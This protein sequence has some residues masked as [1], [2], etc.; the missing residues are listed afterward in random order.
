VVNTDTPSI[1]VLI[2]VH[3]RR[4]I[5]IQCLNHLKKTQEWPKFNVLVIDDGS[6]DGTREA[7]ETKFPSVTIL[8]GDGSL[9][10]GGS[11]KKGMKY[12]KDKGADVFIWLND[13]VHPETEGVTKLADK[14][15]ELGDTVLTTRVE[16]NS[17]FRNMNYLSD[18][19]IGDIQLLSSSYSTCQIKTCLGMR[20]APY[21]STSQIQSCDATA[22]KFTAFPAKIVDDIGYPDDK[23]FPHNYCDHDYTL[24][25]K[26]QGFKIGVY[27]KISAQDT[28]HELKSSRLS[29]EISLKELIK[30]NFYPGVRES[31]NIETRYR[32]YMQF[33]GPP[34]SIP[35]LVF[36]VYFIISIIFIGVKLALVI[37][38]REQKLVG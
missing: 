18:F 13:D 35:Y 27:T 5:T 14:T 21:D 32:R 10:W 9:W 12:A 25:A 30:N 17:E 34:K 3:N 23:L 31:Y 29:S 4:K 28:G 38:K 26:Q 33:Y 2:P 11:I 22:G 15:Y 36:I 8:Q 24:R 6:T 20:L 7:I 16:V 37:I 19:S 1:W